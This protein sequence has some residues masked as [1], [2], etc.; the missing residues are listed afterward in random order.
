MA[1]AIRKA[2]LS[3]A[4]KTEGYVIST[5]SE[6]QIVEQSL[7]QL[8]DILLRISHA[9]SPDDEPLELNHLRKTS[10]WQVM[11]WHHRESIQDFDERMER[12]AALYSHIEQGLNLIWTNERQLEH[13][14][15]DVTSRRNGLNNTSDIEVEAG[16]QYYIG[17][18]SDSVGRLEAAK[19]K[20]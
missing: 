20:K 14:L 5:Q 19:G 1:Q 4:E 18:L 2:L 12:F 15:G 16:H 11:L 3:Q 17:A 10:Y 7:G 6:A 8:K 9:L 13:M